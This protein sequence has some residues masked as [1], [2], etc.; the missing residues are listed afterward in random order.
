VKTPTVKVTLQMTAEHTYNPALVE[1]APKI[2]GRVLVL[3]T[4]GMG[5]FIGGLIAESLGWLGAAAV[6][7]VA[8]EWIEA[9]AWR[10]EYAN[11]AVTAALLSQSRTRPGEPDP[12]VTP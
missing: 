12:E 2:R 6:L 9:R 8:G 11:M 5:L 4:I 10:R 3:W 1:V 7:L